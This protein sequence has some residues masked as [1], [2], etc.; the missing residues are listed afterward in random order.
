MARRRR[1]RTDPWR[2]A[3]LLW[4]IWLFLTWSFFSS[5][6]FLNGYYLAALAPPMAA[7]CGLGFALAWKLRERTRV[8]PVLAMA[9]VA[10]GVAYA[11][12]LVPDAAGVRPWVIATSALATVGAVGCLASSLRRDRRPW[13]R[14]A[15]L[16]LALVALLLGGAW[17]SATAVGDELGPFDSPYQPAAITSSQQLSWQR[18]VAGWP[19]DAARAARLPSTLSALTNE[20]SAQASGQVLATGHEFLA[21]G[22]F[23][24]QVPATPLRT[25]ID[26]V[27]RHRVVAVLVG[28]DPLTRNPD[29]RW[30]LAH[31]HAQTGA[32]ATVRSDNGVSR[33]YLCA[34]VRCRRVT[35]ATDGGTGVRRQTSRKRRIAMREPMEP[36]AMPTIT[37]TTL[38]NSTSD[39]D[40]CMA[41][42]MLL[43]VFPF[44]SWLM[45]R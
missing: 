26:D 20:S 16:G 31:C 29:M 22:G 33:F 14:R 2:A 3:A 21:V 18:A 32:E 30:V 41:V 11:V 4:G 35:G 9:A 36:I 5:S 34:P 39:P 45:K 1:P 15:G 10:V 38:V 8:V 6:H 13:E 27:R 40:M 37:T 44:P 42:K 17:A 7:L 43:E 12:Y 28:T 24:G 19:A 23:S 25:F